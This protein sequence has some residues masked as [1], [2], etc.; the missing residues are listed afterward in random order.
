MTSNFTA[1]ASELLNEPP[2]A[3]AGRGLIPDDI[4]FLPASC[5][6]AFAWVL[7]DYALTLRDEVVLVWRQRIRSAAFL[8]LWVR[9][10]GLLILGTLMVVF[11]T[12]GS[13]EAD[14]ADEPATVLYIWTP[15]SQF[16]LFWAVEII[17]QCRIYALYGSRRLAIINGVFFVL[18]QV[19]MIVLWLFIP[20]RN[21]TGQLATEVGVGCVLMPIY[22][23]PALAFELWLAFLAFRKL[24]F[25][26]WGR[27]LFSVVVQDSVIYFALIAIVMI[28]HLASAFHTLDGFVLPFLVAG[29]TIGGSRL[30]LQ[31]R[32]AYYEGPNNTSASAVRARKRGLSTLVDESF[33]APPSRMSHTEGGTYESVALQTFRRPAGYGAA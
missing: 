31:L 17:L 18:E 9:Y 24:K 26:G 23:V 14:F 6:A 3:L 11:L 27:D 16:A 5:L 32:K 13:A 8:F 2:A 19:L 20:V 7:H 28:I 12:V 33:Y 10:M 22:W 4:L 15:L 25:S 29:Q 1:L 30:V 21:C